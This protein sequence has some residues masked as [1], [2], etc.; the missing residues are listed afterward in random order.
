M[1]DRAATRLDRLADPDLAAVLL[2]IDPFGLGG[3][4]LRSQPTLERDAWLRQ[5]RNLVPGEAPWRKIP[6]GVTRERLLGGLDVA[7]TLDAG[8]PIVSRGILAQADG[9]IAVLAMAERLD[10]EKAAMLSAMLDSGEVRLERD[11]IAERHAA[12]VGLVAFDEGLDNEERIAPGLADRMAF[13][14]SLDAFH[15]AD[16]AGW[17]AGRVAAARARLAA[18]GVPESLHRALAETAV[19]LGVSS[20]RGE[21]L[22]L[23]ATR[24][25]AAADGCEEAREAHA[26]IAGRL[27]LAG[28]AERLPAAPEAPEEP[29]ATETEAPADD[30]A[31]NGSDHNRIPDDVIMDATLAA[32]PPGLLEQLQRGGRTRSK[33]AGRSGLSAR[34]GRKGRRI[35][36]QQIDSLQGRRLDLLATLKAAAPWQRLRG[37]DPATGSLRIIKDDLRATRY[38]EQVGTT[39]VFAV[40]ASGSQAAQRLGEVKAALELLLSECYVR[41]D[42]VALIAFRGEEADVVLPPTRALARA[43]RSLAALPAGGPTPLA[44]GIDAAREMVA[45]VQSQGRTPVVVLMTDGR[46]N[47]ARDGRRGHETANADA[48]AAARLYR[49]D[50]VDTL[51]VDTA[52]RPKPATRELAA[53]MGARYVPLPF[54]EAGAIR[55]MVQA[56]AA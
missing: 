45:R 37:S 21:L 30:S 31:R 1:T 49:C 16:C 12:Q 7:A 19:A 47:V 24:A 23:R 14:V 35:G 4:V 10:A 29:P 38:E 9:G 50:G 32:L 33:A 15:A 43:R 44:A 53:A 27:V 41:R 34:T 40:D 5:L 13:H 28:R 51:L 2:A 46:S 42:Q 55:D 36:S 56:R 52:R 39:T 18:V 8:Q 6:V 22:A 48:L 26:A 54:P 11:G 25:A 17:T 20:V 3:A